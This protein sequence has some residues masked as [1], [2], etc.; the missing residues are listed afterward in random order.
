MAKPS[1]E[2][3]KTVDCSLIDEPDGM[4][5]MDIDQD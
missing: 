5:R 2:I 3:E 1:K 4:I